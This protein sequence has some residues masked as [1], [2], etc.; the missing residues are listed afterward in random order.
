M[1]FLKFDYVNKHLQ[2]T[3]YVISTMVAAIRNKQANK[4]KD[5][6]HFYTI[7]TLKYWIKSNIWIH[8]TID[9]QSQYTI[10]ANREHPFEIL[11]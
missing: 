8:K 3:F 1:N 6:I 4:K 11:V 2:S 7:K 5:R 10:W 9:E